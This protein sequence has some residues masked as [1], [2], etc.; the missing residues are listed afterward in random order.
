M[1]VR[2]SYN[3]VQTCKNACLETFNEGYHCYDDMFIWA[4]DLLANFPEVIQVVRDRFPLLF[5][6]EAQDNSE[7]QSA[8][9]H[10]IFGGSDSTV[11]RQRFGDNNQAIF[12]SV[13]AKEASIDRFPGV[14]VTK[15]DL[16]NSLRFGQKIADLADPLGI[17][18]YDLKG[19]G[20][21]VTLSSG[22]LEARHT[23]FLF[24]DNGI[25]KVLGAYAELLTDTFS[26]QELQEGT[27]TAVGQVHRDN[28]DDQAPRHVSHY[29]PA[30][31]PVLAGRNPR[32]KTFLQYVVSGLGRAEASEEMYPAVEKVAEGILRL[33]RMADGGA[34][35]R[36]PRYSHRYLLE[37]LEHSP[38][39]DLYEE[40]TDS[41]VVK[42]LAPM[43]EEW[44]N[45]CCIVRKIAQAIVGGSLSGQEANRFLAWDEGEDGPESTPAFTKNRDNTYPFSKGGKD[46]VIRV[47]SIHSIKGETHMATLVLETFWHRHNLEQLLPWLSGSSQGGKS[48]GSQQ[49]TRLKIHYVAMTR[50]SH[51]LCLAMK[52]SSMNAEL[53]HQLEQRGWQCTAID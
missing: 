37:L 18:P 31:N 35:L 51:L 1:S 38:A 52:Q 17:N 29:W 41:F 26:E 5:I 24:D 27:F 12:D 11:I 21:N 10:R 45:E 49:T 19:E 47:G 53:V 36:H 6:D 46:V 30:Y 9:L 3:H 16:P 42:R 7:E 13:V 8:I 39:R 14:S 4:N 15:K 28:G 22:V 40:M 33:A 32:P 44:G 43:K 20:P 23:I 50:P 48:I 25:D 34:A 2:K